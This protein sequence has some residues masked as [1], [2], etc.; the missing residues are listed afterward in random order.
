MSAEGARPGGNRLF[1]KKSIANIQK[2]AAKSELKRSLG[3]I[4][5]M[6]LGVGA[7]LRARTMTLDNLAADALA[8]TVRSA[9]EAA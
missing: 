8:A 9:R 5:L 7:H 3:P 1:L 4:N 6:S 2:E